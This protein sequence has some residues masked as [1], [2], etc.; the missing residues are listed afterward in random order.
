MK[1]RPILFSG[2]M[3]RAILDERKTMTR[4]V[5]KPQPHDGVDAV[6]W[7]DQI[8]TGMNTP[9]QSGF[10]MMRGGVIESHAIR[11]P[12]GQ[13]GD[14]LWVREEH[15]AFGRWV[16]DGQTKLGNPK[17]RFQ[18]A[19]NI[20]IQFD[21]PPSGCRKSRDKEHPGRGCWYQRRARFMPRRA[22][23]ITL[24]IT[25]VRV[26]R[27]QKISEY[28][29]IAEG[30]TQEG[31]SWAVYAGEWCSRCADPRHTFEQLWTHIYGPHSWD[32]NPWVWVVEFK[33]V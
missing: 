19:A 12:Y 8:I 2:P 22:S 1:D 27:L 16:L 31:E 32:A 29:A 15:Y 10:A 13:P 25:S 21:A 4:R 18:Q 20:G 3:V 6:E 11:C 14:R 5:V 23:R 24:E 9:D 17:W 26:E 28:D 7:Q 30:L 33:K